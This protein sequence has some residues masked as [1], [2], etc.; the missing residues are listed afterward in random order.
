MNEQSL[1]IGD[2]MPQFKN[3]P[4][5]D[6]KEHSSDEFKSPLVILFSCN[7]YPYVQAYEDR[8]IAFQRDYP[9][10]RLVAI[11]SNEVENYPE[12]S[13]EKM[14]ERA[15]AKRFNFPYLRD[16]D[17]SVADAFGA[18][19]TPQFFLFDNERKLRYSGKMDDNWKE[20]E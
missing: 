12:D 10:I 6:G 7:H 17:Q 13:F 3:L 19:H 2:P 14:V 16:E 8:M 5:V 11:N 4:G 18:T 15:K 9:D 1:R 20:P